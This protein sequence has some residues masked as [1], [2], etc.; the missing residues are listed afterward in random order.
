MQAAWFEDQ[1]PRCGYC[2]SG[3]IMQ[4]AALLGESPD[5]MDEEI[6]ASMAENLCRRMAYIRI[7]KAIRLPGR[8]GV[9][10]VL[11]SEPLGPFAALPDLWRCRCCDSGASI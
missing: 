7:K 11:W 9:G 2:R 3:Q 6:A 5:P 4:A 8:S 10:N 1:A